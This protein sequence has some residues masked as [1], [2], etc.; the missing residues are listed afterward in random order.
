MPGYLS[1]LYHERRLRC[2]AGKSQSI[3][4]KKSSMGLE[5]CRI[6]ELEPVSGFH[7]RRE[8]VTQQLQLGTE[9]G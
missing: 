6:S 4:G 1:I 9:F 7:R 5:S 2:G 3:T 8:A